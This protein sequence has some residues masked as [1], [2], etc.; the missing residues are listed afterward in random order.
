[1]STAS[2]PVR[3]RTDCAMV[4]PA[5]SNRVKKT[6]ETMKVMICPMLPVCLAK[7]SANAFSVAVLVSAAELANRA[8]TWSATCCARLG[9]A[10]LKMYQPTSPVE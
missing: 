6:A 7:P 2:S 8:S 1:M 9:S 3:S 4:L 10:T 5:T